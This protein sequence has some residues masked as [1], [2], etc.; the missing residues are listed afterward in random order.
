VSTS[1]GGKE[2][3][4]KEKQEE[5]E[6]IFGLWLVGLKGLTN[7]RCVRQ[8]GTGEHTGA[9]AA[10]WGQDFSFPRKPGLQLSMSSHLIG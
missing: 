5:G 10:V 7:L 6:F 9:D 3:C 1:L 4:P 2:S 8:A